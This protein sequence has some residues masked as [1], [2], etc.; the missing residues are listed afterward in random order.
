[1]SQTLAI[2]TDAY[3][4]LNSKKM[5]WA[6]LII[7]ALVVVAFATVGINE[8]GVSV[9][10][11]KWESSI[12]NTRMIARGMF[13]KWIFGAFG[14][15][16]WLSWLAIVL[17]LISTA[18]MIPDFITGGSI[19]LY[20]SKP[21]SRMRL[22]LTKYAS[23][24]LFVALQVFIFSLASFLVI[25]FRG[26][27]WDW[28][29]F[30]AVP[31]V[32]LVFSYLY[33][34]CVFL[35]LLTRSTIAS[36]LLTIL[37][38]LLLYGL[39]TTE[40]LL[41][42]S[43]ISGER[44]ESAYARLLPTISNQIATAEK[45]LADGDASAEDLIKKLTIQKQELET[46]KAKTDP[47]RKNIRTTQEAFQTVR[48]FLPKTG[49]ATPLLQKWMGIE[50]EMVSGNSRRWKLDFSDGT[51]VSWDDPE[52][53]QTAMRRVYIERPV[54][55]VIGTSLAFEAVVLGLAGWIFCRRD[56]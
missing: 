11:F 12:W 54:R 17:A 47:G 40:T 46:K 50:D 6:V 36:L 24:L 51:D 5:F 22:F 35:G 28:R 26:Q 4:E 14:V 56:Y 15:G 49:E 53:M 13:Y 16:A 27:S 7:S 38:W 2:F 20:V 10:W 39:A 8:R 42:S 19:D 29:V 25:G 37:F 55:W 32:V 23:G 18:G 33:S 43:R 45:S 52:S 41:M 31:V 21:I 3:R 9:L 30:A 44:E 1:M 48:A 34:V